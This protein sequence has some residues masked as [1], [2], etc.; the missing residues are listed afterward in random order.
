MFHSTVSESNFS[1]E[2]RIGVGVGVEL[3]L[4]GV[5]KFEE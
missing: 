2:S 5:S 1:D 4:F 3:C